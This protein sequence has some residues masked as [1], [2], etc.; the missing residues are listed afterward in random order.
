MFV[1]PMGH[2]LIVTGI[3]LQTIGFFLIRRII[4]IKV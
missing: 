3:S 2:F 1:D 4:E